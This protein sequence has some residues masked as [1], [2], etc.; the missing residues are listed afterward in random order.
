MSEIIEAVG[1]AGVPDVNARLN[2]WI[3]TLVSI[4]A[5]GFA[6]I[7]PQLNARDLPGVLRE[8][9]AGAAFNGWVHGILI[10]LYVVLLGSYYGLSRRLGLERPAVALGM[11][12]FALGTFAM[13]G[14]A[15]INGFALALFSS[16]YVD[17]RPDQIAAV[18]A[19]FNLAGSIAMIWAAVGAVAW[20][21]GIAS[22]SLRLL[23]FPGGNRIIGGA[24][25]LIGTG[26]IFLLVSGLLA[27]DVHGF[28]AIVASQTAW[29]MAVGAQLIRGRL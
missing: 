24:G 1:D 6:M 20:A 7:H 4:V 3:L 16:R 26:T 23:A 28:L 29:T 5:L 15:V 11:T 19:S 10:A 13:F 22:W 17:I 2:G 18:G 25:L 21:G 12:A 8:M 14:A 27:L 9:T